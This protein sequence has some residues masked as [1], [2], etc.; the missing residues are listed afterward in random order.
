MPV[1]A[2]Q[3]PGA[4]QFGRRD[5]GGGITVMSLEYPSRPSAELQVRRHGD[6][7]GPGPPGRHGGRRT[8]TVTGN[9]MITGLRGQPGSAVSQHQHNNTIAL[10]NSTTTKRQRVI[11]VGVVP[12]SHGDS[13]AAA[14]TQSPAA[15][16]AV[17]QPECGVTGMPAVG[18]SVTSPSRP[19]P[20]QSLGG[21][22]AEPVT[23]PGQS[24]PE[25]T[26][27]FRVIAAAL[28][29]SVCPAS[30]GT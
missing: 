24:G 4:S 19:S 7:P 14:A 16:V 2:H 8:G 28:T 20:S 3:W 18:L 27:S 30:L 25:C 17:P 13:L 26:D 10:F 5:C 9:S 22:A 21:S 6:C 29:V 15:T 11:C 23:G 12:V 1:R